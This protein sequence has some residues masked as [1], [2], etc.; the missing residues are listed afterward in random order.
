MG[1]RLGVSEDYLATGTERGDETAGLM[2]AEIAMRLDESEQAATLFRDALDRAVAP[3]ERARALAGLGQLAFRAGDPREAI[4]RLE[5]ARRASP[6]ELPDHPGWA[7]TLGRA[8]SMLDSLDAAIAIFRESLGVAEQ[9]DDPV[10]RVRFAVLLA[11]ALMD[12]NAFSE[13]EQLL[14]QALELV[15]DS[16]DPIFRARIYWS[17]SRLHTLQGNTNTA[18]RYA[19]RALE[20]LDLTEDTYYAARAH[21][22]LAHIEL[23]RDHPGEALELI[24]NGIAMLA[25]N[26]TKVDHALFRLEE[27]R[28]LLQLGERDEAASIAMGSAG[29]LADASPFDAA[30]GY[31]VMAEVFADLGDRDKA[32]ELYEL[33]AELLSGLPTRYL[34]EVYQKL[35]ALLEA[36]GR[37]DEALEVLKRAVAVQAETHH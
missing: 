5:E 32:R 13:A 9:R 27:A 2:D 35:A 12:N 16:R 14:E 3:E 6:G 22:L 36:D 7:D 8:Y 33:A 34:F 20:L 21:Q 30:R 24:R 15:P 28:A 37:K 29:L 19:R 1:R 25:D 23:D 31:T 10:E 17:H 18:A 11:N 26:G 4:A